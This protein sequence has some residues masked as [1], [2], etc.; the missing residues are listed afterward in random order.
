MAGLAVKLNQVAVLRAARKSQFPDPVTA[1]AM[2]EVAGADGITVHLR[3]DRRHIKDRDVRI[4][5]SIVQS[6]LILEMAS[7]TEMVGVALDIK[8]DL[9]TLVPEKREEST[10]D[11]GLDLIVHRDDITETVATLQNSGIPAGLL[12]DPQPE[13]IRLAHKINATM[14]E[15]HTGTYCDAKTAQSRHQAFLNIVDAVK[16]AYRLKLSVRAGR[17]LCYKSIKA[18]KGIGEIDEFSIGHSIISRSIL[19]GMQGAVEEMIRLI[20]RL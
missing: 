1:A 7:T 20:A 9:V 6:K 8:P 15:V 18:F 14:V 3:Q 10:A 2:A 19:A 11:G 16:L 12:V 4:L 13:Q 17:G 5:R